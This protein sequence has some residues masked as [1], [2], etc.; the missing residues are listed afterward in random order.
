MWKRIYLPAVLLVIPFA[1]L[2]CAGGPPV[3]W[4]AGR[5]TALPGDCDGTWIAVVENSTPYTADVYEW[6]G[7]GQW[8]IGEVRPR[9]T[10]DF[11]IAGSSLLAGV[12]LL[13]GENESDRGGTPGWPAGVRI[14]Y[15]CP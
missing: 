11:H 8:L 9:E 5:P 12:V 10:R 4:D 15:R 3:D 6:V 13:T 14:R 2:G 1:I 7:G